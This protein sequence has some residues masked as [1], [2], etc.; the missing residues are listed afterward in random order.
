MLSHRTLLQR[1]Q[2]LAA[3]S[4]LLLLSACS[5]ID[6][7]QPPVL[8]P[9]A[10]W[11]V[12]PFANHT[13]TPLAGNRAEAIA[14]A[15][16]HARGVGRVQRYPASTQQEALFDSGD[17]K[18]QEEVLAWARG[19][20]AQYALT[21]AVDEWRYKVG[22]DGEPAAGVTLRIVDVATGNTLWSGAGG[23]SGWSREALSAVAQK[24]IR[25]LL[26]SGLAGA[27]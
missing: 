9:N 6:R 11:V 18:R 13:E 14:E 7:G 16:L 17:A 26:D 27:R 4:T 24:L 15:L 8:Q 3:G 12:L 21:G 19:Q 5:T 1:L 10:T 25:Q 2:T 22:V 20:Q 23:K